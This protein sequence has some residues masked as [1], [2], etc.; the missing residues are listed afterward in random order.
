MNQTVPKRLG[1]LLLVSLISFGAVERALASSA[2]SIVLAGPFAKKHPVALTVPAEVL[3]FQIQLSSGADDWE[4]RLQEVDA[5]RTQLAENAAKHGFRLQTVQ[6]VLLNPTAGKFLSSYGAGELEVKSSILLVADLNEKS[7][8]VELVR[9]ARLLVARL[10]LPKRVTLG[11]G[12]AKL[13]VQDPEKF[14]LQLLKKVR[15]HID[16]NV[17]ALG[18]DVEVAISGLDESVHAQQIE[19]RDVELSLPLSVTYTRKAK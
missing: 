13:G 16:A 19:E 10:P 4:A 1:S 3:A 17:Q 6:A 5:V 18:H 15:E 9:R 12:E 2:G 8:L 14:R 7:D 11:L